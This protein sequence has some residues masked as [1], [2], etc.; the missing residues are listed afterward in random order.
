MHRHALPITLALGAAMLAGC[1]NAVPRPQPGSETSAA[2]NAPNPSAPTTTAPAEN[3]M[4]NDHA[5]PP[6]QELHTLKLDLGARASLP[7]GSQLAYLELV[8]DS[9]CPPDVRCVWAG[10]AEIRLRWTSTRNDSRDFT[11]NTSPVG[12]KATSAT[13][14]EFEIRLQALER[15]VAP[16][17]TLEI[18][19]VR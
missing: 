11:L 17:A 16:A 5:N 4:A 2:H 6:A 1:S 13:L 9:R 10:N 8:N 3:A 7:D 12:G 18:K 15:G 14:G 19:P